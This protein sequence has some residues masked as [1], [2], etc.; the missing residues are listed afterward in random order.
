MKTFLLRNGDLDTGPGG[1]TLITGASKVK[2]DLSVALREPLGCDR[3]HTKW[4]TV[5]PEIIGEAISDEARLRVHSE[6]TRLVANYVAVQSDLIVAD[7]SR[8]RR[9][10]YSA[11]EIVSGIKEIIIRQEMDRLYVKVVVTTSTNQQVPLTTTVT[12]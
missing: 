2:Q 11:D 6:V 12:A 1:F 8:N 4:G 9:T 3:F 5:L 7:Y 10:R